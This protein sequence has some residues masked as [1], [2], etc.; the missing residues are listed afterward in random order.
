M[1]SWWKNSEIR[2]LKHKTAMRVWHTEQDSP[3][4]QKKEKWLRNVDWIDFL[5]EEKCT[6]VFGARHDSVGESSANS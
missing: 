4:Y 2:K 1:P 5:R 6:V 3:L